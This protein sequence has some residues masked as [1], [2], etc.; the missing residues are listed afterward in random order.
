[1]RIL[2][3]ATCGGVQACSAVKISGA[4]GHY[5]AAILDE[6]TPSLPLMGLDAAL[7]P[8]D[9]GADPDAGTPKGGAKKSCALKWRINPPSSPLRILIDDM[10]L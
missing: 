3:W 5:V 9:R 7:K 8:D 6:D 2:S 10:A 1:M 4:N